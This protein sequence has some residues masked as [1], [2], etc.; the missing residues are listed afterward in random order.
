MRVVTD[1]A[2][3]GGCGAMQ[4]VVLQFIWVAGRAKFLHR[5]R[6]EFWLV[7]GVGIMAECTHAV[8]YRRMN[9]FL[10]PEGAMTHA[11]KCWNF[12]RQKRLVVGFVGI[13]TNRAVTRRHWVVD[14]L[15]FNLVRMTHK[16][17]VLGRLSEQFRLIGSMRV[18][19]GSTHAVLYRWMNVL[20]RPE[21][22][23]A[24]CAQSR[25]ILYQLEGILALLRMR[26]RHLL[27]TA[28]TCFSH[29]VNRFCLQ[30]T[31]M[32]RGRYAAFI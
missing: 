11:A 8:L 26:L 28:V 10:C 9:M 2:V 13:V 3:P 32:A 29:R 5:L 19:A 24:R 15:V 6:Q 17:E 18:M 4:I 20:L 12:L 21:R 16:A 31:R 14:H 27:M 25:D 22:R 1:G 7:D 23:V 30:K